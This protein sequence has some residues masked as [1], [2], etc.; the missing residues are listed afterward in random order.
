[1]NDILKPLDPFARQTDMPFWE[2]KLDN[3]AA[4]TIRA[5][6]REDAGLERDFI[7]RLA[8]EARRMRFLCQINEPSDA[9][10][11]SLTNLDFSHDMALIALV[12]HEGKAYEIGVSRYAT[13][14]D[15]TIGDCAVTVAD[16]WQHRGLGSL[17]MNRLIEVARARGVKKLVSIDD[18]GNFKMRVM[19]E[20]LGFTRKFDPE[21]PHEVDY[22]LTL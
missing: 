8:P 19:A 11:E 21:N 7:N 10:I 15:R 20:D 1:M 9:L 5:I 12:E 18:P 17:L 16:D 14:A 3:G 22:S 6:R 13:G 2:E 4:V